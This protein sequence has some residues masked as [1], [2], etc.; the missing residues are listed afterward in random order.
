MRQRAMMQGCELTA[1]P[2]PEQLRYSG[3]LMGWESVRNHVGL[4]RAT[5]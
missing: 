5:A 3:D 2:A 1:L 4:H